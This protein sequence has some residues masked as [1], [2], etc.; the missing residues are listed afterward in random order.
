MFAVTNA[1]AK[2][3]DEAMAQKFKFPSLLLMENAGRGAA[4][5]LLALYPAIKS[6]LVLCGPGNNGGDGFV[7][8]RYLHLAGKRVQVLLASPA[9]RLTGDAQINFLAMEGL[10]VPYATFTKDL[11]DRLEEFLQ[12]GTIVVDALLGTGIKEKVR[13]PVAG[14]LAV[15]QA[16]RNDVVALDLPSGL[17]GDTGQVFSRPLRCA[18]TIT[19]QLPKLCHTITPAA[20][21]CGQVHV[22]DIGVYPQVIES[23]GLDHI[24]LDE[25]NLRYW[26]RPRKTDHH[27][28]NF[29]HVLLA[30]GS[31][32]KAGAIALSTRAA[33][34]VGAGLA[35]AYIPGSAAC[36]F[37]RTT[38]EGMSVPYGTERNASL[39]GTAGE[40]FAPYLENKQAVAIG[41]GLDATADTA[42]FLEKALQ[43]IEAPLVLDADALNLLADAPK[44][45]KQLPKQTILTPHPG[46]MARLLKAT[47][48]AVQTQRY[49]AARELAT[50]RNVIVVL[51]G[52]GS[53]IATP[54]GPTYLVNRGNPGLATGGTGDVLTGVIVGLLAQGYPPEQ[55]AAFGTFLHAY[56]GDML[57]KEVGQE[58]L[59]ATKLARSLGRALKEILEG[60]AVPVQSTGLSR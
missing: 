57:V 53:I 23:L 43:A 41:P 54:K 2:A 36:A 37:H 6:F 14:V 13:E 30:G 1:Q 3:M 27:K 4:E 45:W 12:G 48:D 58:G 18:H 28:G 17:S 16:R 25:A 7:V 51:K 31:R 5:K 35:T 11:A 50:E 33:L 29:G 22:Q 55:A 26:Y 40:L 39:D 15:L 20:N 47:T 10:G 21:F 59:V 49:E 8:A 42:A 24:L 46:E 32:G 56:A 19:F 52:Q 34:D 9:S 38:L 44:L 60:N